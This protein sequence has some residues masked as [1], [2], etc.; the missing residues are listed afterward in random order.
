MTGR[1]ETIMLVPPSDDHPGDRWHSPA[2]RPPTHQL[3]SRATFVLLIVT[4]LGA[5]AI[6]VSHTVRLRGAQSPGSALLWMPSAA[7][8]AG[9]PPTNSPQWA[10]PPASVPWAWD[11]GSRPQRPRTATSPAPST[12][13]DLT[14]L[15]A[16]VDPALV[17]INTVLGSPDARAAGTGI[18]L[19][20]SGVVLTNNHVISGASSITATDIG[21]GQSYPATV[22][23]YDRTHDIA[24]LQLQGATGLP[25][26]QIG[27]SGAIAAGDAIAG[28]GNAGG[29]GGTPSIAPGRISALNQTV[30]VSDPDTGTTEQ[31][32]GLIQVA[33]DIQPGDSGG[34]LV[35]A[36]GQVIGVDTAGSPGSRSRF[37]SSAGEGLAIPINDAI[38][39]AAQI[40]AGTASPT[41]HIGPTGILGVTVAGSDSAQ[42][43]P[44]RRGRLSYPRRSTTGAVVAGV[45]PG[46]PAGQSGLTAGDVI[47]SLD[48]MTVDSSTTLATLLNPHHPGDSVQ[49]SWL[50][51]AGQHHSATVVLTTG[52][53]N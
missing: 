26:A 34:P 5:G 24:V 3:I 46:S 4:L 32:S 50:D 7:S 18:V 15:A 38:A 2:Q 27:D 39:I 22:I 31:L 48:A 40:K 11:R 49:L 6:G 19:E 14:T 8:P 44:A 43:R 17:D 47:V 51:P 30:T 21:T 13:L 29:R 28:I 25:T 1:I 23:G 35:N 12:T 10:A 42:A 45:M 37:E 20:S 36:A 16:T 9:V 53:P 33:A 52:A 41:I